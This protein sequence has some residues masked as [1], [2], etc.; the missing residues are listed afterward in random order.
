MEKPIPDQ[1]KEAF[2]VIEYGK[3]KRVPIRVLGAT[4]VRIHCPKYSN[5]HEAL[6]RVL[7][8]IDFASHV[9]Y[10]KEV[11]EIFKE[12]GYEQKLYLSAMMTETLRFRRIFFDKENNR[13]IDVFLDKLQ[14][15]HEI[16]FKERLEVDYP[17]LPLAELFLTKMQIVKLTMKDV[18][19]LIVLLMEH[20]VGDDDKDIINVKHIARVLSE[21]WGFYYTVTLNI[22]KLDKYIERSE[23]KILS[24]ENI[25][26]AKQKLHE[27]LR[28][29]EEYPK[30]LKWR[31]RSKIGTKKKWYQE[32]EEVVR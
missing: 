20:K 10:A 24:P 15:C 4:A 13:V 28:V 22:N 19:D 30:T 8:D 21:D 9:K 2:R 27:I 7:T 11:T 23:F 17:T 5:F 16:D 31:M 6:G 18:K 14:M 3:E 12:L 32:V 29:I 26:D 25:E 1:V